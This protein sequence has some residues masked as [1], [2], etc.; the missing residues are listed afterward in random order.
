MKLWEWYTLNNKQFYYN[1]ILSIV[2]TTISGYLINCIYDRQVL[3][4]EIIPTI[5]HLVITFII[6]YQISPMIVKRMDL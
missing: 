2:I 4:K 3:F 6:F 1:I 5:I